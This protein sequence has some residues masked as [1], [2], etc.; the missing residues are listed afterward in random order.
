MSHLASSHPSPS[1][2]SFV[3]GM[4]LLPPHG[5]IGCQAMKPGSRRLTQRVQ[6]ADA[7]AGEDDS[8]VALFH[9]FVVLNAGF[10]RLAGNGGAPCRPNSP[11]GAGELSYLAMAGP[12]RAGAVAGSP[13]SPSA[14]SE[15]SRPDASTQ[16]QQALQDHMHNVMVVVRALWAAH[17]LSAKQAATA[18]LLALSNRQ[19][20]A[21]AKQ[22]QWQLRRR[23]QATAFATPAVADTACVEVA[24]ACGIDL[25][26]CGLDFAMGPPPVYVEAAVVL[27]ALE[28]LMSPCGGLRMP[29]L[30]AGHS[31]LF[32]LLPTPPPGQAAALASGYLP[33]L[34][35]LLRA[36]HR[37][38]GSP[39]E[40][41][42]VLL[43][44][45]GLYVSTCRHF[46]PMWA[47]A[48]AYGRPAEVASLAA[49]SAQAAALASGYLPALERLLRALHRTRGSPREQCHV[50]LGGF[51]LYV[52]T[53]RHFGPM[54]AAA[55]AYGRPAEVASL[56]ATSAQLL[57]LM[58]PSV[59]RALGAVATHLCDAASELLVFWVAHDAHGGQDISET[60]LKALRML[61]EPPTGEQGGRDND[62]PNAGNQTRTALAAARH[63]FQ[64]AAPALH[65]Y[66]A[67]LA[68]E[69]LGLAALAPALE[70]CSNPACL[71][72]PG[73]SAAAAP[74]LRCGGL[75][76]GA[77]S[78][79]CRGC[80]AEHWR[81]GH[82]EACG[83]K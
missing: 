1:A 76:G 64:A 63:V 78:Y 60:D 27:P 37:T 25:G 4:L 82:K 30:P 61:L 14:A 2:A 79:C 3:S 59:A 57:R 52:S 71:R 8:F 10:Y 20:Q 28:R 29:P 38:R 34:E 72:M 39:R 24:E 46:G 13:P 21:Q 51:G 6:I 81:A 41:C 22:R 74:V 33:A 19:A 67:S 53:C 42:H 23:E 75:C 65:A 5:L 56:A 68:T 73:G 69:L 55:F 80:H 40:Q 62:L 7:D 15:A 31:G 26:D 44:G 45:F 9:G 54:W 83:K 12:A 48:F 47:A 32:T 36:L 17:E 77:V 58:A 70:G 11:L 18:L 16:Q 43:G 35:R 66:A 49:T 50:L